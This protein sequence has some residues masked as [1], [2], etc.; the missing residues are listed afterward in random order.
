MRLTSGE[1]GGG[2]GGGET[3]RD[4]GW[5][6]EEISQMEWLGEQEAGPC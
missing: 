6:P 3:V 5:N 2:A 1:W 4:L